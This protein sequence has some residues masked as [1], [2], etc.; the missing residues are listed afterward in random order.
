[1]SYCECISSKTCPHTF[2][3]TFQAA[4]GICPPPPIL[5][6]QANALLLPCNAVY[7]PLN[8]S[9]VHRLP[10]QIVTERSK[11]ARGQA[12]MCARLQHSSP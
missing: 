12:T 10:D 3:C 1:M 11:S 5:I 9:H 7:N 2:K 4:R 6:I 8:N